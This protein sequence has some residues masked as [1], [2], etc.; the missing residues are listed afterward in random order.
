[1]SAPANPNVIVIDAHLSLAQVLPL[2]YSPQTEAQMQRWEKERVQIIVPVL[3]E[4]EMVGGLRRAC[5]NKILTPERARQALRFLL[6]MRF[7]A[8]PGSPERHQRALEW[9]ERLGQARVYDAQYLALAHEL[10]ATLWTG[11]QRLANGV[12]QLGIAWVRW[13]GEA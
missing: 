9:A 2:T 7:E 13:I 5:V 4:Y 1:M 11:D 3:W 6:D 12:S 10:G 8:V